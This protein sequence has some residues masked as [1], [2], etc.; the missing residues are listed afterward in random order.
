MLDWHEDIWDILLAEWSV[1]R[2]N[3]RISSLISSLTAVFWD[4]IGVYFSQSLG[5]ETERGRERERK[6]DFKYTEILIYLG[7]WS[8]SLT[9]EKK[10]RLALKHMLNPWAISR[11]IKSLL[12]DDCQALISVSNEPSML[13]ANSNGQFRN[14]CPSDHFHS[15]FCM[16]LQYF[17]SPGKFAVIDGGYSMPITLSACES[18]C[19]FSLAI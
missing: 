15:A 9:N 19:V 5:N 3:G 2:M 1:L 7:F 6:K 11:V 13:P 14:Q 8:A 16:L 18:S 4:S 10:A 17:W 12:N